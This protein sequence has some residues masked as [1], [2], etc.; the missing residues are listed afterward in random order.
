MCWTRKAPTAQCRSRR[1]SARLDNHLP[2]TQIRSRRPYGYGPDRRTRHRSAREAKT[3][4]PLETIKGIGPKT[5]EKLR[6][7]GIPDV[8]T[9]LRTPGEKLVEVAGFDADV[10]RGE[11]DKALKASEAAKK[12]GAD[13]DSSKASGAAPKRTGPKKP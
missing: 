11:A 13:A 9:F 2:E 3:S 6:A 7:A 8:E 10:M 12:N 4:A 5:A 1:P